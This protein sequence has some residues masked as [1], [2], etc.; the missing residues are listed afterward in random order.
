MVVVHG[1]NRN[2]EDYLHYVMDAAEI[3]GAST[4]AN[5]L[6][7]APWFPLETDSPPGL[8][9]TNGGWK[10]GAYSVN[11]PATSSYKVMD[12]LVDNIIKSGKFSN[13]NCVVIAGHSAGGQFVERYISGRGLRLDAGKMVSFI[14]SNPSSYMYLDTD[15][16]VDPKG[17]STYN[18]YKYGL[19]ERNEYMSA[20]TSNELVDRLLSSSVIY[21]LGQE[22]TDPEGENLDNSC[23]GKR[24]GAF[25]LE[26]GRNFYTHLKNYVTKYG[27]A[28][29]LEK[30]MHNHK[31]V[32]VPGIGH[33]AELMFGSPPGRESLFRNCEK[34]PEEIKMPKAP[35]DPGGGAAAGGDQGGDQG[36]GPGGGD[37]GVIVPPP[38][39]GDGCDQFIFFAGCGQ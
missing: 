28:V 14:V 6:I 34:L 13:L 5:T 16:P 12:D 35:P 37:G 31:Q 22:D 21:L 33:E 19:A 25:R 7:V 38:P 20:I 26:R 18:N 10:D 27:D 36:G 2:A 29:L 39:A 11:L 32:E 24:Q 15:R 30:F 23:A 4:A 1:T 3:D 8:Y 17:C 9:W